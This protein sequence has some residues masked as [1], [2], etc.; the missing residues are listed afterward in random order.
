MSYFRSIFFAMQ[1]VVCVALVAVLI[2]CEVNAEARALSHLLISYNAPAPQILHN[3]CF[4]F[5]LGNT[6]VPREIENNAYAKFWGANKVHHGRCARGVGIFSTYKLTRQ[7]NRTPIVPFCFC[8][9]HFVCICC[10]LI[11]SLV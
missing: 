7:S 10:G 4:S 8:S 5:L 6:S 3:L 11:L 1:P 9:D 2:V